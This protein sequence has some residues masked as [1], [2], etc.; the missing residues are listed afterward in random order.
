M[1]ARALVTY[2]SM[3]KRAGS[4][5]LTSLFSRQYRG[6]V[7]RRFKSD[8]ELVLVRELLR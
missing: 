2:I 3:S 6:A 4:W 7:D 1:S 8:E 5:I